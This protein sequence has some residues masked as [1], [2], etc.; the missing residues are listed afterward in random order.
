[1]N[2][3]QKKVIG[4]LEEIDRLC[5]ENSIRYFIGPNTCLLME[6]FG[7]TNDNYKLDVLIPAEDIEN[8]ISTV[9]E[10]GKAEYELESMLTNE[11][12]LGFTLKYVDS[13]T[14]VLTF[15][16]GTNVKN[17]GVAIQIYPIRKKQSGTKIKTLNFL[18]RGWES[19]GFNMTTNKGRKHQAG[20]KLTR[21]LA[22]LSG[23]GSLGTKLFHAMVK[24]NSGAIGSKQVS[25][26]RPRTHEVVLS[27]KHFKAADRV[28][29]EGI[30]VNAP[31]NRDALLTTW[32]GP[33]WRTMELKDPGDSIV[34]H[35][36][37]YRDFLSACKESGIDIGKLFEV[38]RE[39]KKQAIKNLEYLEKKRNA[40]K[41]AKRSGDRLHLYEDL[42][43][44]MS[45]IEKLL[46]EGNIDALKEILAENEQVTLKYL[47]DDLGFAVNELCMNAQAE[48]FRQ[49]GRE[50]LA[51]KLIELVPVDHYKSI[52][53]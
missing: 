3:L 9:E 19:N 15:K 27:G 7:D 48:I 13:T 26:R 33:D 45:E 17:Y 21:L 22:S 36:V 38:R 12:Y 6:R 40:V 28:E 10:Q 25:V 51:D 2:Q 46:S 37:P 31:K 4:L 1:M 53:E 52:I 50:E 14:T 18:E 41:I 47:E 20:A 44:R 34:I 5:T 8:F 49:T 35:N 42:K 32:Y 30:M 39:N 11:D 24:E 23:K 29:L 16:H 43:P